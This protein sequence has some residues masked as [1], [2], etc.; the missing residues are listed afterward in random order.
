MADRIQFHLDENVDPDIARALRRHG[1]MDHPGVVYC[2]R[3]TRSIGEIIRGLILI[4]EVL[5]PNEISG[6]IEFL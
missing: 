4:Y 2:D 5:T 6:K 1:I 3:T